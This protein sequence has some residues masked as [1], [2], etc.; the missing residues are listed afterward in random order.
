MQNGLR[1]STLVMKNINFLLIVSSILISSIVN[2]QESKSD[3]DGMRKNAISFNIL[4][5]TPIIGIT[6]ERIVSKNISVEVGGGIPSFGAGF[7]YYPSG[8]K[9]SQMLFHTG[10]SGS[11]VESSSFDVWGTS[12]NTWVFL[13]YLPIGVSYFGEKGFNLGVD[14]GP[15]VADTFAIWGNVKVGYRF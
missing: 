8:I 12:D 10:L 5:A 1:N 13:G 11:F 15:A 2:A 3:F 4:G 6:Y 14:L 9:E 7:K